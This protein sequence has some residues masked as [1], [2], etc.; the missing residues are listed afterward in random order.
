MQRDLPSP[1]KAAV[2]RNPNIPDS[3]G[4]VSAMDEEIM[5]QILPF[6]DPGMQ[7]ELFSREEGQTDS[8]CSE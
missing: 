5:D 1:E 6:G 2:S 4:I 3:S 8:P 7:T